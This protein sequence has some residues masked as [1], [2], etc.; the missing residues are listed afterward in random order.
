MPGRP[1]SI[2][3]APCCGKTI[4]AP[5]YCDQH[6][7]QA[8]KQEDERRGSAY[9][10]GYTSVWTK[11]RAAYLRKHPLCVGCQIEKRLTSATVVDHITPHKL[12]EAIDSGDEALIAKARELFW[13]S[14]NNWASLCGTCHN[15][16]A[17]ACERN[18]MRKPWDK[19]PNPR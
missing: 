19:R 1:R 17:Q 5:G 9:E 3:R 15:S 13:D 2:C 12:K 14:E 10:R 6:K 18:G 11:A 8:R 16:T 7:K 4:A